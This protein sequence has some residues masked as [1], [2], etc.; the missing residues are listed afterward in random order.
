MPNRSVAL[1]V[2]VRAQTQ[3]ATKGV[4]AA[5]GKFD[6][7]AGAMSKAALPAAAV[8]TAI[9][10]VATAAVSA[11]SDVEQS[12]G[13]LDSVFGKNADTVK[14]W[15]QTAAQDVG[16][17]KA[18]YGQLAAG[19]GAQLKNMGLGADQALTG[20]HDLIGLGADLSAAFGGTATDAVEA[21]G[22][23]LR[24][25]AD[26]AEK[27]GLSL[28]QAKINARLAEKG[29]S[30]LTG[31]ALTAAKAQTVMELATEQAG[32]AVGQFARE[33]DTAAGQAQRNQAAWTDTLAV[34][35]DA[36]LPVVTAVTEKFSSLAKWISENSTLV[37][38]LVGVIGGLAVAI[39]AINVALSIY[40]TVTALA[41]TAAWGFAA[42][43]LANP[44]TWIVIAIVALVVAIIYLWNNCEAF[45]D[46]V[47]AVWNWIK[48]VWQTSTAA[49]VGFMTSLW[50]NIVSVWNGITSAF[51]TAVNA[52]KGFLSNLGDW[53][54]KIPGWLSSALGTVWNVVTAPFRSAIDAVREYVSW[55]SS[56]FAPV[57]GWISSAL[58]GIYNAIT[59]PFRTA[60]D[61]VKG[62]IEGIKSTWN[63]VAHS[64]NSVSVQI[65]PVPDWVPG[66]GGQSWTFDPPNLPTLGTGG[67]VT[68]PTLALIG[69]RGA[70]IV[71]PA[72]ML[73][74][75]LR[76]E[77]GG[78][79]TYNINVNVAAG[80]TPAEVGRSI[81][82]QIRAFERAAG[83]GWRA[84]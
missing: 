64:I 79:R 57:V 33:A 8:V 76:E 5:A 45:R 70:E 34:L 37:M 24:G 21:L 28:N 56:M 46:A 55:F 74:K 42:A 23:A 14:K 16:I 22:S 15:A 82:D 17:N 59:A 81:V 84:A 13:A 83:P 29:L 35:G 67:Y 51:N 2:I 38:I 9:G 20:T 50:S 58:S 27:Y 1:D 18:A 26:P 72:P 63:T 75:M 7:F 54:G 3:D 31:T 40:A 66:I 69:E 36:L 44:I 19:M 49:I 80:V 25:E 4:D 60:I 30:G 48:N 52:V 12:M 11:A 68:H 53:F 71:A 47:T 10:G 32:G 77:S 65:G 73:R 62:A 78:G 43:L 41:E 6:K 61:W 39:L